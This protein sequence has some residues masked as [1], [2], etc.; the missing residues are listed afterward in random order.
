VLDWSE[1][2]HHISG[3]VGNALLGR[4]LELQWLRRHPDTRA[5]KITKEGK[6]NIQNIFRD[7]TRTS[8][9]KNSFILLG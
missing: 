6:K 1:R 5:I 2:R 9:I 8:T 7:Y 4:L 3:T